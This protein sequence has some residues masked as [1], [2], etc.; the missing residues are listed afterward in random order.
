MLVGRLAG[1]WRSA[2]AQER[3]P[4]PVPVPVLAEHVRAADAFH[5]YL[6]HVLVVYLGPPPVFH[7][8][9]KERH[10]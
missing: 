9:P 4:V 5:A 7:T 8:E 3:V 6:L 10:L 1:Q 2:R